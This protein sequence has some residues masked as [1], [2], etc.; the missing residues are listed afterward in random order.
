MI[1]VEQ[2]EAMKNRK[3]FLEKE[4]TDLK[5]E[6]STLYIQHIIENNVN[7]WSISY[8][9]SLLERLYSLKNELNIIQELFS[10]ILN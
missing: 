2:I 9:D 5:K 10:D 7:T 6:A 3:I 8:Y 4:I 1:S